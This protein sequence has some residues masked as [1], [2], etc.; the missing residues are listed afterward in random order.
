MTG[1]DT[2]AGRWWTPR[3]P[4]EMLGASLLT[5]FAVVALG[6]LGRRA[7]EEAAPAKLVAQAP[8]LTLPPTPAADAR[9]A[10][11]IER[12]ALAHV[13]APLPEEALAEP[14]AP[15]S[16]AP[17][18]IAREHARPAPAKSVVAVRPPTRPVELVAF[19]PPP[20]PAPLA[21]APSPRKPRGFQIPLVSD[22]VESIG[23]RIPSGRD[24]L[25]G[26]GSVGKRI[27]AIFGG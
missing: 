19:E 2:R 26:V 25:D 12:F 23:A 8:R 5:L 27:G 22:A 13:R 24:M 9:T 11:F 7:H 1:F 6:D 10:E 16:R 15:P 20:E 4:L 21:A 3:F 17:V 14:E 18:A